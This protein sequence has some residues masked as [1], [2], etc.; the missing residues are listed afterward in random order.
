MIASYGLFYVFIPS[1]KKNCVITKI[2]VKAGVI[3]SVFST[4]LIY[5][6]NVSTDFVSNPAYSTAVSFT[7]SIWVLLIYKIMG[8]QDNARV[9]PGLGIVLFA[10]LLVYLSGQI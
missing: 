6:S 2:T 9:L 3:A 4:L 5:L 10:M 8:K 1:V 7:S